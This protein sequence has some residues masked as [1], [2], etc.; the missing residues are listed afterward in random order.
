MGMKL[1]SADYSKVTPEMESHL[2]ADLEVGALTLQAPSW[3]VSWQSSSSFVNFQGLSCPQRA[4]TSSLPNVVRA[5]V[6]AVAFSLF[7][8]A[9]MGGWTHRL[10]CVLSFRLELHAIYGVNK[11]H[12]YV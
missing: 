12:K 7:W 11:L 10:V 6:L 8:S 5:F 3:T 9:K 2:A 1:C 4:Q